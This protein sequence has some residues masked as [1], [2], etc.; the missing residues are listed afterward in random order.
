MSSEDPT[1]PSCKEI[2][3]GLPDWAEGRLDDLHQEPYERH[4]ELCPPCGNLARTYR[5]LAQVAR[6]ALA[7]E[8]PPAARD[9]LRKRLLARFRGP[10]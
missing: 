7:V 1:L 8:M 3:E 5:A 6:S 9:R 10:N 4:L 2:V